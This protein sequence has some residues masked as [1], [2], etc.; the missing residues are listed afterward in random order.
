MRRLRISVVGASSLAGME[1]ASLLERS[2]LWNTC[3][4]RYYGSSASSPHKSLRLNGQTYDISPFDF[5]SVA[6]SDLVFLCTSADVSRLL[7]PHLLQSRA[8][9]I[10]FS[11]AYRMD[12]LVPLCI[13]EINGHTLKGNEPLVANPN[14][15]TAILLMGLLPLHQ[16]AV[17]EQIICASYQ[18][19]SGAGASALSQYESEGRGEPV[20]DPVLLPSIVGNLIPVIGSLGPS[21]W[22]EEEAK[23]RDESRKILAQETLEVRAICVRVPTPRCHATA[24][25]V[26]VRSAVDIEEV[27]R[28]YGGT[29]GVRLAEPARSLRECI[30]SPDVFVTRIRRDG[31]REWSLWIVGDNLRKGAATNALQIAELLMSRRGVLV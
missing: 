28:G 29:K 26:K 4:I 11:S 27:M 14:C 5:E 2:R 1:L 21:G 23:V 3:E 12:P 10:D 19:V 9:I 18:S 13:P 31:P 20:A 24:A 6:A 25:F 17:V 8:Q 7:V 22:S 16:L 15:T 30:G